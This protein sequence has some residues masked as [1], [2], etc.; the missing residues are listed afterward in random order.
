MIEDKWCPEN[1]P[2]LVENLHSDCLPNCKVSGLPSLTFP[3]LGKT[4]TLLN[5]GVS[6]SEVHTKN[7]K[8]I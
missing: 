3:D 7:K 4:T 8:Y 1:S 5:Y 2:M 6:K